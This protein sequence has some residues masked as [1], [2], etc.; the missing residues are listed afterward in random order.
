MESLSSQNVAKTLFIVFSIQSSLFLVTVIIETKGWSI[1]FFFIIPFVLNPI[2]I[3]YLFFF[4]V[5]II[6]SIILF[7]NIEISLFFKK[8]TFLLKILKNIILIK[9][10]LEIKLCLLKLC[11]LRL[12]FLL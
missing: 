9:S 3:V 2:S 1:I 4:V 6:L 11:T 12:L 5:F 8:F 10:F 7:E